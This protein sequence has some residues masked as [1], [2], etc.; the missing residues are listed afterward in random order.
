MCFSFPLVDQKKLA[1]LRLV[2]D[3]DVDGVFM[4]FTLYLPKWAAYIQ[5]AIYRQDYEALSSVMKIV[6]NFSLLVYSDRL[7]CMADVI[8]QSLAIG[9]I[10]EQMIQHLMRDAQQVCIVLN[11]AALSQ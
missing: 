6:Q 1:E 9:I 3:K 4:I 10:D 7:C 5:D 11:D 2:L 8:R